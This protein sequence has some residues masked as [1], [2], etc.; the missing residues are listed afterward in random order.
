MIQGELRKSEDV[1]GFTERGKRKGEGEGEIEEATV[2][3]RYA[4]EEGKVE[5][6]R[7]IESLPRYEEGEDA[8]AHRDDVT[9]SE[10]KKKV[11]QQQREVE[12]KTEKMFNGEENNLDKKTNDVIIEREKNYRLKSLDRWKTKRKYYI[13]IR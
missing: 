7:A 9:A 5:E 4:G 3:W 13:S 1:E 8:T 12:A 2:Y 11:R 10:E 6:S